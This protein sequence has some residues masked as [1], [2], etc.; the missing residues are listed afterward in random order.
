M[1]KIIRV[2]YEKGVLKPLEKLELEEG[3]ELVVI[4]NNK[5]FYELV[6][7]LKI[8]AKEDPGEVLHKVRKR[9]EGLYG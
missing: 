6:R 2:K 1:I 9:R 5:S 4:L 8:R 3:R 7:K